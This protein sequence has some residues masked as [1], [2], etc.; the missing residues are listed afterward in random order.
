MLTD[1]NKE[2]IAQLYARGLNPEE[3]AD[4]IGLDEVEVMDYCAD[5]LFCSDVN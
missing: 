1:N 2:E 3:I 4:V 5:S